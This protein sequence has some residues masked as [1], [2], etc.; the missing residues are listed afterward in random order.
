MA[1]GR[2]MRTRVDAALKAEG[3]G[4]R[5]LSA[6]G[7]LSREPGLSYSELGR[8]ASVT[9]QSMQ[10]TLIRLQEIGAVEKTGTSGRGR[11]A[12]LFVTDEGRRLIGVG[13][14]A[15]AEL[16]TFLAEYVDDD[17]LHTLLPSF[18][19]ALRALSDEAS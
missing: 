19:R 12:Q 5:H 18:I 4:V 16:D 13:M 8:R 6:L 10:A 9:P 1:I 11:T 14:A 3:I 15:Y 2:Q 7:H 17:A